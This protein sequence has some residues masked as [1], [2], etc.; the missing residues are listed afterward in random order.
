MIEVRE[1]RTKQERK[2]FALLHEEMY[3]DVP[4]AT[5]ELISDEMDNFNPRK[6]P[7]YQFCQVKQWLAWKDGKPVGRVA[8]ILNQ[9]AN[10]KWGSRR[11]RFT[12]LDFTDDPEVSRAL[13]EAVEDW[14]RSLG[15]EEIHGPLGF[16]DMDQEG[17]LVEGFEEEG[18]LITI[19]NAPYYPAHMEALGYGKDVDWLEYQIQV[20]EETMEKMQRLQERVLQR[21]RLR[22]LEPRSKRELKPYIEK[23]FQLLDRAYRDLYGTVPLTPALIRKYYQQFMLLIHPAYVKLILDQAGELVGLGVAVPSVSRAVKKSRG[24]LF[25]LGWARLLQAI[26][27]KNPVLDL[28]LVG[29]DAE[30]QKKGLPAVLLHSMTE[31][32]R[33]RGVQVAETGPELETNT[34]VQGLWKYYTA[35]QHRRRRCWVKKL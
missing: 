19:H 15:Q 10:E 26:Y 16:C 3:R 1:V 29:V 9:A 17:M 14:G 21:C 32:A 6:N 30:Y 11:V 33:K 34:S 8:G 22:L 5:P 24:R 7:A 28:Y 20:P 2:Q 4:Q 31:E 23:A 18:M 25:P 12:R 27:G 35:R 13:L